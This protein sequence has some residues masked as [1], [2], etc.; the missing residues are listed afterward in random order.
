MGRKSGSRL[1]RRCALYKCAVV[2][3]IVWRFRPAGPPPF[4]PADSFPAAHQNRSTGATSLS[5][6]FIIHRGLAIASAHQVLPYNELYFI[7]FIR[8]G[9]CCQ[10]QLVIL[11]IPCTT[12]QPSTLGHAHTN[13]LKDAM[14]GHEHLYTTNPPSPHVPAMTRHHIFQAGS[15]T[16]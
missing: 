1:S 5:C 15:A 9:P 16:L 14:L 2:E 4:P 12:I 10:A 8:I 3:K 7:P 6:G 11:Y 13:C